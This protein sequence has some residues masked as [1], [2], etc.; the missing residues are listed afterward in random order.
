M[1][2]RPP[3]LPAPA[4]TYEGMQLDSHG[5]G[6]R[7]EDEATMHMPLVSFYVQ[8]QPRASSCSTCQI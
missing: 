3:S 6:C 2:T 1:F 7:E 8:G 5:D 4:T